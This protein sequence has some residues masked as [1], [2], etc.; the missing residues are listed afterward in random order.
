MIRF[1][2]IVGDERCE[3]G[4]FM[5]VCMTSGVLVLTTPLSPNQS[6]SRPVAESIE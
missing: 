2:K 1:L 6:L 3:Y 5:P 4:I